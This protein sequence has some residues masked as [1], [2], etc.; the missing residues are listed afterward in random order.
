M[1]ELDRLKTTFRTKWGAYAY[2]RIP[3][4]LVN[5]D[6][7]FKRD[8]DISFKVLISQRVVAYLYDVT[9]YSKKGKDH[10]RHMKQIFE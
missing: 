6:T 3:F 9:I 8:M 2:R 10:P 1:E 4:G 7:I 5:A